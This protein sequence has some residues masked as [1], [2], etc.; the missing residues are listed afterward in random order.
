MQTHFESSQVIHSFRFPAM[1]LRSG[2]CHA[3]SWATMGARK[4]SA[5]T[6]GKKRKQ[7]EVASQHVEQI[8]YR[9]H[10]ELYPIGKGEQGVLTFQPYKAVRQHLCTISCCA[11]CAPGPACTT[12]T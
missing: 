9:Q 2:L 4:S 6:A 7:R 5:A 1:L 3:R 10:P 8:D 12:V 11:A